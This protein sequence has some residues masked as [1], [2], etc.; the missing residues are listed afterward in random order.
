MSGEMRDFV[1]TFAQHPFFASCAFENSRFTHDLVA[2][3]MTL[4]ELAGGPANIENADLN[5]MYR[6]NVEFKGNGG[7]AVKIRRTLKFL[8]SMFPEKTPELE[9]YNAISLYI[10]ISHLLERYAVTDRV[11]ALAG[12]FIE[13]ESYRRTQRDLPTDEADIHMVTY[14]ERTS[15]STDSEDS[16]QWR[17]D[18]LLGRLLDRIPDLTLKDDQRIFTHDQRLAIYRRDNGVCQVKLRCEGVK[19]EWD[20][21]KADHV[22]AWSKGGPTTVANR[23]VACPLCNAAKNNITMVAA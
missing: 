17:H 10:L 23:Q 15:H 2:A 19:C 7:A 9:R 20:H 11:G 14:Q 12:W 18:Y 8:H 16:L 22:V 21:W 6:Q 13:F 4:L 1:K 3:Q 5:R